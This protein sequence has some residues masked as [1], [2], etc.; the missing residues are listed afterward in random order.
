MNKSQRIYF[1]SGNTTI[2]SNVI[3]QL[4]QDVDTIEFLS[5]SISTKDV[6][7]DFNADYGVLVGRVIANG[8][9]G[10]PNAKISIF[11]PLTE[12]DA[13][14]SE[15]SSLYPYTTPRDKNI[16]GKRYNLLPRVGRRS[17]DG[18]ISPKQP[19]GSFPIKEETIINEPHL[20][21]YKK[22]YKYTALTN[23]AGDY[24]IFGVPIGTQIVHLSVDIT[25]IG[26]YSMTPAAMVT[27]LGYSPNLFTDNNTK[28]KPS[29]DLNDLPHIET[30]EI[31]VDIVPFWGDITNFTIGITRQDFRIRS[32]LVNT[33]VIFGSVFTDSNETVGGKDVRDGRKINEINRMNDDSWLNLSVSSKRIG[34]ITEKIYYYPADVSD[35]DIN[36]GNVDPKTQMLILDKS[37]YSAYTRDGD[38]AFIINCNRNK[39]ITDEFGNEVPTPDTSPNGVFTKF[40]GFIT[41]EI[42]PE[43]VP[44]STTTNI[45]PNTTIVG[46]RMRLK[47]PQHAAQ[48]QTFAREID[49]PEDVTYSQNS[50]KQCFTFESSKYYSLARFHGLVFCCE[51]AGANRGG[52]PYEDSQMNYDSNKGFWGHDVINTGNAYPFWNSGIMFTNNMGQDYTENDQFQF[53]WN[54]YAQ[55]NSSYKAFGAQWLNLTIYLQ[56]LPY[57]QNGYSYIDYVRGIDTLSKQTRGNNGFDQYY[58]V[59]NSQEIAAG[60][61]N[62]KLFARSDLHWTD[63]IEVPLADIIAM[64]NTPKKGFKDNDTSLPYGLTV[65]KYR[66]GI[67]P[68]SWGGAACPMNGG[69]N[70][71]I[72][73]NGADSRTYFYKGIG[74]ADCIEFLYVLGLVTT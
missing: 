1:Q 40:R 45:G 51:D 10:I 12:E 62:T 25:D 73:T 43:A 59:N 57:L 36:S 74:D 52:N 16:D 56:Q 32:V 37:Q 70:G 38:F 39:V 18:T 6:Y 26:K 71:G 14:D 63:I 33:F 66:N 11:I 19:F 41:L 67:N 30:Q 58:Y 44:I 46:V 4:E 9:I 20:N 69:K 34:K 55:S 7:Q 60:D 23:S 27:N 8:G 31:S 29:N 15:I 17:A 13:N 53:P 68:P 28:I 72:P 35:D 5:M 54:T 3:V 22:Y 24:M 50:R 48:N 2:D 61:F 21:I 47:F 42:T 49:R 65:S 64:K